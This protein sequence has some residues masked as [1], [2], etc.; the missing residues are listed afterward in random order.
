MS[1]CRKCSADCCK[2]I[3]KQLDTPRSK[4]EFEHIRWYLAHKRVK[5]FIEKRKWYLEIFTDCKYLTPSNMCSIY[6]T[7][8]LICREHDAK[9]CEFHVDSMEHDHYFQCLEEFDE[10]LTK[11]FSRKPTKKKK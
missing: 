7:R 9:D 1:P 4:E 10:Y 5:V 11:R 3:A 2:Y 6:E 8:P